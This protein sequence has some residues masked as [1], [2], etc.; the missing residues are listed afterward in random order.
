VARSGE[1]RGTIFHAHMA[2]PDCDESVPEH[3]AFR[4]A[5][6]C[7]AADDATRGVASSDALGE[8]L[9]LEPYPDALFDAADP[10]P[11]PAARYESREAISLAFITALQLLPP[12]QRT[13]HIL[14]DVLGFHAMEVAQ[15]LDSTEQSVTSALKRAR[16][17]LKTRVL[18]MPRID[19][20]PPR[21]GGE[22]AIVE[23]FTR[24]FVSDDIE[25]LIALLTEE[26]VLN[27]PP[28]PFEWHGR[29]AVRGV[30]AALGSQAAGSSPPERIGS[31]RSAST[32]R[33]Q[34]PVCCVPSHCS[35]SHCLDRL[36]R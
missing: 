9:W 18:D 34:T 2:V 13:V 8:V 19:P 20:P 28:L 11:G 36:S 7:C 35:F 31:L 25:E 1:L 12:R 23:R 30:L 17:I 10:A 4:S 3:S 5:S 33:T 32:C 6:T 26:V 14:R 16:A 15:M 24:A 27:M 21:S 22:A 29:D